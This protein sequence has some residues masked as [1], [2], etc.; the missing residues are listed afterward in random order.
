MSQV[1]GRM[2]VAY[3]LPAGVDAAEFSIVDMK[4]SVVESRKVAGKGILET[5]MD[6]QALRSGL[7]AMK[8]SHG[9]YSASQPFT[10]LK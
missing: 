3:K 5:S 8:V 6:T 7:Y 10:L 9:G 1:S 4:G 2:Q